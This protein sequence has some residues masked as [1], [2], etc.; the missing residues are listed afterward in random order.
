MLIHA[1]SYQVSYTLKTNVDI[2][3]LLRC[4][5]PKKD[6]TETAIHHV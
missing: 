6:D 4:S 2:D 1:R 3:Y 5:A